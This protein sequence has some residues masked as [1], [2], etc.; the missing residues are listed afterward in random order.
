MRDRA[1]DGGDP[2]RRGPPRARHTAANAAAVEAAR[3]RTWRYGPDAVDVRPTGQVTGVLEVTGESSPEA[4]RRPF[5]RPG[6]PAAV[7]N[8]ASALPQALN[9]VRAGRDPHPGRRRPGA[10]GRGVPPAAGRAPVR[11]VRRA[12]PDPGAQ[13]QP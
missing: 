6:E 4:A 3:T 9:L 1:A 8:F 5:G 7:L 10:G 12:P 13:F 2:W 11:G